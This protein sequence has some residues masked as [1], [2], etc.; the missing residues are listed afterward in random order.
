MLQLDD[1]TGFRRKVREPLQLGITPLIDI[2]FLLLIFFMLTSRFV[3][4][5]GIE[6]DLPRTAR[7]HELPGRE[8]HVIY[9]FKDGTI[10]YRDK[11]LKLAE[12]RL[13]LTAFTPAE[14][15]KPFEVRSDRNATVQSVVSVLE[16]LRDIGAT[17]VTMGTIQD[18]ESVR[19]IRK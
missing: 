3:I 11:D 7:A 18:F 8:M 16:L 1:N 2:V 10:N 9:I 17:R 5:E 15:M 12:L 13:K 4:Q 6:V 19:T 14:I